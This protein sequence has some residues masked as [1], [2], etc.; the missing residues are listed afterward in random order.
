MKKVFLLFLS[1]LS[2]DLSAQNDTTRAASE[3][4]AFQKKLDEEYKDPKQSP[5][6]PK[7][8]PKFNGHEFFAVDLSYR[9]TAKFVRVENASF[10]QLKTTTTRLSTER[11]YAFAEFTLKDKQF[12]LPIY[13]SKDLMA[14]AEYA[15]YLF[16]PFSDLTNGKGSYGGGR[17]IDL[18]IPPQ[19]QEWI[20][21]DFNQA[22]NPYCAYNHK[23]SCP[24]VPEA[25]QMDI[26]VPAGVKVPQKI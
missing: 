1:L 6:E 13:Q 21:I 16:F 9:V 12:R 25:N 18:R 11:I 26:E 7:D 14:S 20:I 3:I 23:Y 22:Y 4:A 15:D 8:L 19:G 5:L 2:L 17:Y 24:L 10:F